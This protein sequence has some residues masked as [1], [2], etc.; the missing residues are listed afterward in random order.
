[1]K[2]IFFL[3]ICIV[4]VGLPHAFSQAGAGEKPGPRNQAYVDSIKASNYIWTFPAWGKKI[5]KRGIDIP[6]PVG[7]M[8]NVYVGSQ[9]VNISD[10]AVGFNGNPLVPL[11]F[12]KFGKVTA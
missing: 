7:I 4:L 1:M 9:D 5:S 11:D 8:T 2:R 6:Y 10:L 12:I 3:V